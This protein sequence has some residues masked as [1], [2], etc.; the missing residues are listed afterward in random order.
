M[1]HSQRSPS[2][3]LPDRATASAVASRRPLCTLFSRLRASTG[4][5]SNL[6]LQGR[7]ELPEA[8]S[9]AACPPASPDQKSTGYPPTSTFAPHEST[10]DQKEERRGHPKAGLAHPVRHHPPPTPHHTTGSGTPGPRASS[11]PF[12]GKRPTHTHIQSSV[13]FDKI[14]ASAAHLHPP[15]FPRTSACSALALAPLV[16]QRTWCSTQRAMPLCA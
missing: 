9:P 4:Q 10:H 1:V 5:S 7:V 3:L 8:S 14:M 15:P 12:Q 13:D 6:D 16:N 11:S 2:A